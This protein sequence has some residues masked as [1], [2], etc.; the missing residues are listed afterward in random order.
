MPT[1]FGTLTRIY[2][3]A[4][5]L[6]LLPFTSTTAVAKILYLKNADQN[7]STTAV[8]LV[9]DKFLDI[10]GLMLFGLFG[11]LYLPQGLIRL[12]ILLIIWGVAFLT[13]VLLVF[14]G[15]RMRQQIKI[16]SNRFLSNRLKSIGSNL[17][18]D[19]TAL[20]SGFDLPALISQL[21]L[22]VVINLLRG[23]VLYV[24]AVA[25]DIQITYLQAL[26]CRAVIGIVNFIPISNS[27]LGTR[28]AV[29]LLVL[30]LW[31]I[32][33]DAAIAL[34]LTAFFWTIFTK[35]VGVVFWFNQPLPLQTLWSGRQDFLQN[36]PG[37]FDHRDGN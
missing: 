22:A 13:G 9:F 4:W 29:L 5:F 6:G 34:G 11:V 8:S 1:S 25:L 27:G 3:V 32:T 20:W 2:Y 17:E 15:S 30:P 19:L 37:P 7:A 14:C 12:D 23:L 26:A 21:L 35:A 28:D 24:L 33:P 31:G 18:S 10:T 36:K 16:I